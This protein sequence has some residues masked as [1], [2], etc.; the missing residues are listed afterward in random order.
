MAHK[1]SKSNETSNGS[2]TE[3][4]DETD[5]RAQLESGRT[6]PT[7]L[8]RLEHPRNE[9]RVAFHA[10]IIDN[11][12]LN[13][14]KSKC[15]CI[16]KKPLAFGESSS[17]DDEDCEHCFGHPEK[18]QRNA[19]HNHDHGDK[20]CT[21]ASH[22]DGPSTSSQAVDSSQPPAEPVE[23][24]ADPKPPTPGVDFEQTGSS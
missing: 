18:R 17:E 9:R 19:K 22:P 7:L 23:S 11:E 4:I 6:T 5:S 20:P 3:I 8:L 13:R 12:H 16:Y 15:C 14:K 21:E 10:G 24:Q 1:Q 2:T